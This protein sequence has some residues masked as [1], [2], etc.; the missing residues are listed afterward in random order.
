MMRRFLAGC[1]A[2]VLGVGA[3]TLGAAEP[4]YGTTNSA[5][6]QSAT[7][8]S[9][10][11]FSV[12]AGLEGE[13]FPFFAN[14]ASMRRPTDRKWGAIAIVA[15]NP[16][17]DSLEL[18][19]SVTVTGWSDTEIQTVTLKER[20]TRTVIFAPSFLPRLYANHE[21]AAA[22]ALVVV[23]DMSGKTLSVQTTP[24][25][26]RSAQDIYW[27]PKFE[28]ASFIAAWVTPHEPLVERILREAKEFMPGR[29]LPGYDPNKTIEVQERTTREQAKAIYQALQSA[30]VSYVKSSMTLGNSQ[31]ITERV[32]MPWQSLRDVSA[33]C[34]DGAVLYASLFENLGMESVILLVPGHSYVGVRLAPN[35][36]RYLYIET[37]IIGRASFEDSLAAAERG[38]SI[39][40]GREIATIDVAGAR[41][42]GIYPMP[43][44]AAEKEHVAQQQLG[45]GSSHL[46][47]E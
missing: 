20:E 4:G 40:K 30:G 14:Y 26:I 21:I 36:P 38:V 6:P 17:P 9:Q 22:S 5:P 29:R 33:N 2:V 42:M 47:E 3:L 37:A 7:A 16:S 15:K 19:I 46:R 41:S 24:V 45:A 34:I 11:E 10:P 32:R 31:G 27:G 35:S 18:R 39:F 25:V 23:E 1:L 43:S 28:H 13:I 44:P 8:G 12:I